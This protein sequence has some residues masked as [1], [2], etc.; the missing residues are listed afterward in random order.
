MDREYI[1]AQSKDIMATTEL[2]RDNLASTVENNDIVLID[3]WAGWCQPCLRF[4]PIFHAA[5]ERHPDVVFGKLDTEAEQEVAAALDINSIPTI[6]A[7][8]AGILVFQQAGLMTG[9]QVDSL[10]EQLKAIDVDELKAKLAAHEAEHATE[11]QASAEAV[12][13]AASATPAS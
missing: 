6:M 9:R 13:A 8:R 4:S 10:L 2:T 5:S 1:V 12:D 3:F 11:G 7:F